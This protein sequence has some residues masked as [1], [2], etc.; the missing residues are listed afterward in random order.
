M[1]GDWLKIWIARQPRS[2]PRSIALGRPP[3]GE[4]C[5]PISMAASWR[6][7]AA[8]IHEAFASLHRPPAPCTS[9][10]RAPPCSTGCS[11]ATTAARWCCA[12]RT[13]TASARRPR[14]SSRSSTRCA[15][16][17]ST[18]TRGRSSRAQR[19]ERHR[20]ALAGAARRPGTPTA[21]R[22]TAEDVKAYKAAARRRARLPRRGR[23]DE[24]AVRLRVPDGG[25][26]RRARRDPRRHPLRARPPRRPGDRPRRRLGALQL[27]GR[28]RRPR[29]RHH[30]R[31]ARRGSPL[32][33]AQAA[34]GA[35]GGPGG[36]VRPRA[37]LPLYAHLP[38]LHG[39]DG[40]KLSKRH[41]AAS[42]QELRDAGYLPAAVRNYLALL[43]WGAG[44]D[45]TVL[46]TEELVERFTLERVSRN[47]ARFDEVKLRWLDG[48]LHPRAARRGAGRAPAGVSRARPGGQQA[49]G[50]DERFARAVAISQEKI[51]TLA[52]FWP[53]AGF[54]F[55]GRADRRSA[56]R[57][58]AGWARTGARCS[59][60]ARAALPARRALTRRRSRRRSNGLIAAR[61]REAARGLS[62]AARGDRRHHD[63]ARGSSRAWLCSAAR[64]RCGA[65]TR[66]SPCDRP[67]PCARRALP[68]QTCPLNRCVQICR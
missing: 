28:D 47:P 2:T 16:W 44:D 15:G 67:R 58:S 30:A 49:P 23:G 32:E 12:S 37:P 57:A 29:R 27:R 60:E 41:G 13:P 56:R 34:A 51:Q 61:W 52:D 31:G 54:L 26:D 43:G 68:S 46:S 10:A 39:P 35:G 64:R 19:A 3:A 45:A 7:T 21:R 18:G 38:L 55:D 20:E 25:R 22:A 53:L 24:G 50:D 40:K 1:R 48:V 42:V 8:A 14:T 66:R 33:H 11:P 6:A 9:A 17:S 62:A 4:T 36:R 5:A 65:S 63:L 59:R